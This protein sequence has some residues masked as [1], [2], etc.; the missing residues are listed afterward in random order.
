MPLY[1]ALGHPATR[2]VPSRA[3]WPQTGAARRAGAW[4]AFCAPQC[5]PPNSLHQLLSVAAT[6]SA[7]I[8]MHAARRRRILPILEAVTLRARRC[9]RASGVPR[10]TRRPAASRA[11][12]LVPSP[13]RPQPPVVRRR[14]RR[15]TTNGCSPEQP[16]PGPPAASA[17]CGAR[18]GAAGIRASGARRRRA[19]LIPGVST[20]A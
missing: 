3:L 7:R 18:T 5:P 11:R 12:S 17:N 6:A 14:D 1:D 4:R 16:H 20:E 19:T 2:P 9:R 15:M 13:I 8:T 10:M